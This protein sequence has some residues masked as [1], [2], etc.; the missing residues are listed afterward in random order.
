MVFRQLRPLIIAFL[1]LGG[2]VQMLE[3]RTERFRAA[4]VR[5]DA[6]NIVIANIAGNDWPKNRHVAVT[7][8][9]ACGAPVIESYPLIGRWTTVF[10]PLTSGNN[11]TPNHVRAVA[12]F[13]DVH[14]E[15]ALQTRVKKTL[16]GYLWN[17]SQLLRSEQIDLEAANPGVSFEGAV[18]IECGIQPP[19]RSTA[20]SRGI[21]AVSMIMLG[22]IVALVALLARLRGSILP[23]KPAALGFTLNSLP[24]WRSMS[25]IVRPVAVGLVV[26]IAG[27]HR[28]GLWPKGGFDVV[29][30]FLP[31]VAIGGGLLVLLAKSQRSV[32]FGPDD[33]FQIYDPLKQEELTES[34]ASKFD[35]AEQLLSLYGF[36]R[37]ADMRCS[38]LTLEKS[39]HQRV[40]V[41][42]DQRTIVCVSSIAHSF[43]SVDATGSMFVTC[44]NA[45]PSE[46]RFR[47]ICVVGKAEPNLA[48]A[49]STHLAFI[50]SVRQAELAI[51]DNVT[52][53]LS[54]QGID[55]AASDPRRGYSNEA[56][57]RMPSTEELMIRDN[58][59][60]L[61]FT[62]SDPR[63]NP[64]PAAHDAAESRS[65]ELVAT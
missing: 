5:G 55:L 44:S 13:R 25:A 43:L 60:A 64:K 7:D 39:F 21:V 1:L 27:M 15:A 36:E 3:S 47:R 57:S 10:V 37:F 24:L 50:D 38:M 8:A 40:F 49:C 23:R 28:F 48:N 42:T 32:Q 2:Y 29:M 6:E 63:L 54:Y 16:T 41:S 59:G 4:Q 26:L 46:M 33:P 51:L 61:R 45:I 20:D 11:N 35:N 17:E 56:T 62:W 30:N 31:V 65:L 53:V 18:V 52:G 34:E 12:C 14:D 22:C 19:S 58:C 9:T